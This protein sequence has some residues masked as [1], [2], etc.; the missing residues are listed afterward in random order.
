MHTGTKKPQRLAEIRSLGLQL[1]QA[2][3]AKAVV[4]KIGEMFQQRGFQLDAIALAIAIAARPANKELTATGAGLF[5]VF[6]QGRFPGAGWKHNFTK[7][8]A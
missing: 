4:V 5:F 6:S 2:L 7:K 1:L 3:N 8:T